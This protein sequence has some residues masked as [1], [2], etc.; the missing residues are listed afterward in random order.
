V[1][2]PACSGEKVLSC[3]EPDCE[4]EEEAL[5]SGGK[6]ELDCQPRSERRDP[7]QPRAQQRRDLRPLPAFLDEPEGGECDEAG[8]EQEPHPGWPAELPTLEQRIDDGDERGGEQGRADEV[9]AA[10]RPLARLGN[11][12]RGGDEREER[13]RDVDEKDGAPAPP[14]E[15]GCSQHTAEHESDRGREAEDR[16]VEPERLPALLSEE[17]RSEGS[18]NLRHHRRRRCLWGTKSIRHAARAYSWMSPPRRSRR[19]T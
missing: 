11:E 13:D 12:P 15:I 6:G 17:N 10:G 18:E 4:G 16:T 3:L 9:R 1:V 14:K 19:R 8:R 7:E 2:N 5:Q